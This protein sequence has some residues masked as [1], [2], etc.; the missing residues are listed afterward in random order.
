MTDRKTKKILKD[1]FKAGTLAHVAVDLQ[2]SYYSDETAHVYH[3]VNKVSKYLRSIS[4]PNIW[5]AWAGETPLKGGERLI[6]VDPVEETDHLFIK[7]DLSACSNP[8]FTDHITK[9]FNTVVISGVVS[10][11]CVKQTV[12]DLHKAGVNVVALYDAIDGGYDNKSYV[13]QHYREHARYAT[14]DDLTKILKP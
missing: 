10:Y 13:Q 11:A 9:N 3:A 4:V 8:D 12:L 1:A 6:Y 14:T 7:Q 2:A 5:V